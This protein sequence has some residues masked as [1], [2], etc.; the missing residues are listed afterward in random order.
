VCIGYFPINNQY[1][2]LTLPAEQEPTVAEKEAAIRKLRNN[3]TPGMDLIQAEIIKN[4][5]MEYFRHLHYPI[6]KIWLME[7][8]PEEWN[9][10]NICPIHKK[11]RY[12]DL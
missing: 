1:L 11:R 2:L 8:I 12:N 7:I 5:D 3:K 9:L 6:V 10:S 4:A